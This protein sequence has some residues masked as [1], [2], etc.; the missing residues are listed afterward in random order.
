MALPW[1]N[2][3]ETGNKL[4]CKWRAA[5]QRY[6]A[7]Q[8]H[9]QQKHTKVHS[10]V[11]FVLWGTI[12]EC[13]LIGTFITVT[14][15]YSIGPDFIDHWNELESVYTCVYEYVCLKSKLQS[16]NRYLSPIWRNSWLTFGLLSI[17][18]S[19]RL[20]NTAI[21]LP[22]LHT[23]HARIHTSAR[24]QVLSSVDRGLYQQSHQAADTRAPSPLTLQPCHDER[25]YSLLPDGSAHTATHLK[26]RHV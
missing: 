26:G 24:W 10:A 9:I 20:T 1:D 11:K 7:Q 13:S 17:R 6:M 19:H 12:A 3:T 2:T 16:L 21:Y 23:E 8:N 25:C 5:R 14:L 18:S 4:D 22:F 15:N